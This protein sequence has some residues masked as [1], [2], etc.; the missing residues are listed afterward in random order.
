MMGE[1][2]RSA[3][4][5]RGRETKRSD[6]SIHC[7]ILGICC[8]WNLKYLDLFLAFDVFMYLL[9][10]HFSISRECTIIVP[11]K[12]QLTTF[13]TGGTGN[14]ITNDSKFITII[15]KQKISHR[16]ILIIVTKEKDILK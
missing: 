10:E 1:S 3:S 15:G 5:G 9:N 4:R 11:I 8:S 6:V 2:V 16:V 14:R 7:C 13:E 12:V